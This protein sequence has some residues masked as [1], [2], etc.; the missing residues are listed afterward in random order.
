MTYATVLFDL[1]HTLFDTD[2][3]ET[4]ALQQTLCL[5]GIEDPGLH[6]D[7]YIEINAGLWAAVE[8]G[9]IGA[10]GVRLTRFEQLVARTG[11]EADPAELAEVFVDGLAA[12]GDLYPGAKCV[13]EELS[14]TTRLA[15]VTN[16][17]S[18]VQRIRIERLDIARCFDA[19]VISAEI[20]VA[21]P[22]AAFFDVAFE[23]LGT[24]D[25]G[26]TLI[27]G[28]SLSADMRGGADYG[29]ATC[30]YNPHRRTAPSSAGID[31]EVERLDQLPGIVGAGRP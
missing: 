29:L 14:A 7:A 23:L 11:L 30:W 31:H 25:R 6:L 1:D 2:T 4:A 10:E 13:L 19:V 8:R 27:V 3:S 26:S 16:G 9:E 20:G 12:H 21:K 28:D 18:E 22:A 17:L 24:A 15:L 5:A